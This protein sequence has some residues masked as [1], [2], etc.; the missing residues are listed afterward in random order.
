MFFNQERKIHA[1]KPEK[2]TRNKPISMGFVNFI[3]RASPGI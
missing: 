2:P 1:K 3:L